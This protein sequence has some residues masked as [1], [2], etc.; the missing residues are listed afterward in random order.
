MPST[1]RRPRATARAATSPLLPGCY[2]RT[3]S[4]CA[5]RQPPS[6]RAPPCASL[7]HTRAAAAS[8]IRRVSSSSSSSLFALTASLFYQ[9]EPPP[10]PPNPPPPPKP[11]KPPPPPP[12]NPPKPPPPPPQPPRPPPNP[13]VGMMIGN[14]RQPGPHP[15]PPRLLRRAL[16]SRKRMTM[17]MMKI[18]NGGI[19]PPPLAGY[20]TSGAGRAGGAR[21]VSRVKLNSLA[22][23]CAVRSVTS[24]SPV[25]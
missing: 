22:K 16:L 15:H 10:P 21:V 6:R 8:P 1:R 9:L 7:R 19:S 3:F 18:A 20:W 11:P 24:S 25:L 12:P 2:S 17:K 14:G 23:A 4:D 5:H 13:P